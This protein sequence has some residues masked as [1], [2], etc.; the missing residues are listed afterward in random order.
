VWIIE[1]VSSASEKLTHKVTEFGYISKNFS[2]Q[3]MLNMI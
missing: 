1:R 2:R 3:I